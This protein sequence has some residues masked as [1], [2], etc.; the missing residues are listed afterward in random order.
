MTILSV[1]LRFRYRGA[2][3]DTLGDMLE[4][5]FHDFMNSNIK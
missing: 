3:F 4:N 1:L 2:C 5:T